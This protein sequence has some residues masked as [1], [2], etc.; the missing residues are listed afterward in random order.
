MEWCC[1]QAVIEAIDKTGKLEEVVKADMEIG[2]IRKQ[3]IEV[4]LKEL[5]ENKCI[6]AKVNKL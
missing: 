4:Y 2:L 6:C 1:Q 5:R 3:N